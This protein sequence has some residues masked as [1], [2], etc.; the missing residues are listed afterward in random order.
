MHAV[1]FLITLSDCVLL[2]MLVKAYSVDGFYSFA[3][4]KC[5]LNFAGLL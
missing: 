1:V 4:Y 3:S 5:C 2:L